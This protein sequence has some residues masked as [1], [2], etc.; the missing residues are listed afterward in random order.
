MMTEASP[1]AQEQIQQ[2]AVGWHVRL[3]SGSID[4]E[5]RAEFERWIAQSLEHAQ[6]Y[7]DISSLWQQLPGPIMADRQRRQEQAAERRSFRL[8]RFTAGLACA[9][10]VLLIVVTGF[11]PDY[12]RNPLSDYST[13]IGE[14]QTVTLA[15]G[16]IAHLNTDSAIDVAIGD[17]E[18]RIVLRRGEAE[19]EVAHDGRRPFRV[20]SGATTTEALGTRFI[21]R[22]DGEVGEVSLFQ[23]TVSTSRLLQDNAP[24]GQVILQPGQQVA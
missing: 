13:H 15:D 9:A 5:T 16:S 8:N 4:G 18:R 7:Q 2:E 23:G 6:A 14:Q 21:V 24:A 1:L 12:L 22:Y 19:F 11:F 10:S 20:V 17:R 3:T